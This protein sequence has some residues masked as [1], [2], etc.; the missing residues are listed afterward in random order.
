MTYVANTATDQE[1]MLAA[2]GVDSVEALFEVVPESTRF[3]VME[4]PRPLSEMEVLAER[5]PK[6]LYRRAA[7]GEI[8]NVVGVDI[9]FTPPVMPDLV[10]DNGAE[11]VDPD[12]AAARI[13]AAARR[14]FGA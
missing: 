6:D 7:R 12:E 5:N 14:K 2:I 9:E 1:A 10:I 4:L 13:L 8:D 3:P 11:P